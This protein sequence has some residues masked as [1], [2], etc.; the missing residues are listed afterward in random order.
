VNSASQSGATSLHVTIF[1][2]K[3]Y[4]TRMAAH[5]TAQPKVTLL[6]LHCQQPNLAHTISIQTTHRSAK[7][8]QQQMPGENQKD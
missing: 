4:K 6:E 8:Q 3:I 2:A 5:T 1:S 7:D